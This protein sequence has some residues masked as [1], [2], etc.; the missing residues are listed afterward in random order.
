MLIEFVCKK[1]KEKWLGSQNEIVRVCPQ[2]KSVGTV[3]KEI[4]ED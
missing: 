3:V 4:K 2:C 1:C